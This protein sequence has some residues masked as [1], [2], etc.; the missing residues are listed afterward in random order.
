MTDSTR[1]QTES[2]TDSLDSVLQ[3]EIREF[4]I[5]AI[6]MTPK[7]TKMMKITSKMYDFTEELLKDKE[8][9]GRIEGAIREKA[10]PIQQKVENGISL[11]QEAR[12]RAK[13]DTSSVGIISLLRLLKNDP[14]VQE[15]LRVMKALLAILSEHRERD[16]S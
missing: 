15:N 11:I 14:T 1:T 2:Q 10:E 5:T 6:Q 16:Y 12:E 9:L 8:M 3:P 4:L 7:I 13:L